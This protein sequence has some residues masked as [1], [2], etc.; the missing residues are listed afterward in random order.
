[1]S[2]LSIFLAKSQYLSFVFEVQKMQLNQH[3]YVAHFS[4]HFVWFLESYNYPS[5]E[6]LNLMDFQM[7]TFFDNLI[8]SFR[9]LLCA[10]F[11]PNRFLNSVGFDSEFVSLILNHPINHFLCFHFC[12]VDLC[13]RLVCLFRLFFYIRWSYRFLVY[14]RFLF[15]HHLRCF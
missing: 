5:F 2:S 4:S 10:G 13:E 7:Y 6:H 1:M 9:L 14:V 3:C 12:Q 15:D 8:R 11:C